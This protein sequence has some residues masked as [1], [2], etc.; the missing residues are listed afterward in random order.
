MNTIVSIHDKTLVSFVSKNRRSDT[1]WPFLESC[2]RE[3][4]WT[5]RFN[6]VD[7]VV[8][9]T[10]SIVKQTQSNERIYQTSSVTD[11]VGCFLPQ[12]GEC[13]R[14]TCRVL[15]TELREEGSEPSHP[16]PPAVSVWFDRQE[17]ERPRVDQRTISWW[18]SNTICVGYILTRRWKRE[19]AGSSAVTLAV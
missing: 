13:A 3:R 8:A 5:I 12:L 7:V 10:V 2:C 18:K 6:S 15:M 4:W 16:P 11:P 19:R 9:V 17:F 14:R 1:V